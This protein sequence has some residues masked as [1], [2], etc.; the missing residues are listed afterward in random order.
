M[1]SE[2]PETPLGEDN[3]SRDDIALI[4]H[5][6]S[7]KSRWISLFIIVF[8]LI[9]AVII[10]LVLVISS[11]DDSSSLSQ[12]TNKWPMVAITQQTHPIVCDTAFEQ[13]LA[14]NSTLSAIVAGATLCE[15]VC[16]AVGWGEKPGFDVYLNIS[17]H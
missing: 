6:K 7:Y 2:T 17:V 1:A 14:T 11:N 15:E 9:I 10:I 16:P 4:N 13:L 12:T 8:I 5:P 3:N